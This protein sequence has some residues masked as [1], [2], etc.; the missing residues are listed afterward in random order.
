MRRLSDIA[1]L[2]LCESDIRIGR[3]F[4]Q[5]LL[6]RIRNI[7]RADELENHFPGDRLNLRVGKGAQLGKRIE[8]SNPH[9]E[10]LQ[11]RLAADVEG[12]GR[13]Y[14]FAASGAPLSQYLVWAEYAREHYAPEANGAR[15]R[16]G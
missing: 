4:E 15:W 2:L 7:E 6:F 8:K 5:T 9:A 12:R 10:T 16:S 14:S 11:G 13:V 1:C 3:Q